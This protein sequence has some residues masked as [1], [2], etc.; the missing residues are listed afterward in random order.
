MAKAKKSEDLKYSGLSVPKFD[1]GD[2]AKFW[3]E[4]FNK[5][6]TLKK[7]SEDEKCI[8]FCFA[9]G[10]HAEDWYSSLTEEVK[11]NYDQL[12]A[13]FLARFESSADRVFSYSEFLDITQ[14]SDSVDT[15]IE[16]VLKCGRKLKKNDRELMDKITHGLNKDV[17]NFVIMK[18]AKTLE[19]VTKYARMGQ[20]LTSSEP[21]SVC[22]VH[23]NTHSRDKSDSG[24]HSHGHYGDNSYQGDSNRSHYG[25]K[26]TSDSREPTPAGEDNGRHYYDDRRHYQGRRPQRRPFQDTCEHCGRCNHIS[27]ACK[28]KNAKCYQCNQYGHLARMH[29]PYFRK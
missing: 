4:K 26:R 16:K 8:H 12:Q 18:E 6:G 29:R 1:E 3:L 22:G 10:N 2:S 7:W 23:S 19:Q 28:F 5:A 21:S 9:L 17:R 24:V 25:R 15:Y 13:N 20:S 11:N 14:G 27:S